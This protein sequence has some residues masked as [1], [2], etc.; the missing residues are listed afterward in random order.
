MSSAEM[1]VFAGRGAIG[2]VMDV[3]FACRLE[4]P[5]AWMMGL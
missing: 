4:A 3:T 1:Q 5:S 2:I